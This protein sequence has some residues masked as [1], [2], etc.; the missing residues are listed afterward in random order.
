MDTVVPVIRPANFFEIAITFKHSL[1]LKH[2][3]IISLQSNGTK[4][5]T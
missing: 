3:N 2:D 1:P 5:P 4:L